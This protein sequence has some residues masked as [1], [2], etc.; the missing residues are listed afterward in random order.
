ML[1]LALIRAQEICESSRGCFWQWAVISFGWEI[2]S[3][4]AGVPHCGPFCPAWPTWVGPFCSP[5]NT[6]LQPHAVSVAALGSGL[7]GKSTGSGEVL[8]A[9]GDQSKELAFWVHVLAGKRHWEGHLSHLT[10]PGQLHMPGG[11]ILGGLDFAD[12]IPSSPYPF[13]GVVSAL[14]LIAGV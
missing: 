11:S 3:L 1:T 12:P 5:R 2:S 9:G 8:A 4:Q 13:Q 6:R 14:G 7:C 10:M